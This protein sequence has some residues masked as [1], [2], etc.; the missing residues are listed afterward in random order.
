MINN[1]VISGSTYI[2]NVA[3]FDENGLATIPNSATWSL[4][5]S[6]GTTINSRSNVVISSLAASVNI[7]LSGSDLL[8]SNGA[9]RTLTVNAFYNSTL[10]SNLP[11]VS[12][13]QF[14]IISTGA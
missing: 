1:T 12:S 2:I 9:S 13:V 5:D 7:V 8:I 6:K 14:N 3:F 11:L 10:G 4:T